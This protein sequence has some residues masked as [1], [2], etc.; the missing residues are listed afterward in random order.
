MKHIEEKEEIS[1]NMRKAYAMVGRRGGKAIAKKL[2][3]EGMSALG[4][5]GAKKKWDNYRREKDIPT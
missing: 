1:K 3:K 4:K 2:G 5:K